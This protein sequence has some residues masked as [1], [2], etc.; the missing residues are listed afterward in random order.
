MV[1]TVTTSPALPSYTRQHFYFGLAVGAC[2]IVG[3]FAIGHISGGVLNPAVATGVAAQSTLIVSFGSLWR[4]SSAAARV[5]NLLDAEALHRG[6]YGQIQNLLQFTMAELLGGA[7]AT[8]IFGLTHPQEFDT[9]GPQK[10]A[11][12][13]PREDEV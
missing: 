8:G 11:A 4:P 9:Y 7:L 10:Y 3:G 2:Y 6:A 12:H 13:N 1:L 5:A